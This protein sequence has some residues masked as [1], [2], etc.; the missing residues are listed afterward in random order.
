MAGADWEEKK[1]MNESQEL[2]AALSSFG[3]FTHDRPQQ[4]ARLENAIIEFYYACEAIVKLESLE[5]KE[6]PAP[7]PVDKI[8]E[9]MES[10][11][12]EMFG[13]NILAKED[14]N[15]R[16]KRALVDELVFKSPF[17]LEVE[18]NSDNREL[19]K[20][21]ILK[22][23]QAILDTVYNEE[24]QR[25]IKREILL[26]ELKKWDSYLAQKQEQELKK[27]P[28]NQ[29]AELREQIKNRRDA[30][31]RLNPIIQYA[32]EQG[33]LLPKRRVNDG[34]NLATQLEE[35]QAAFTRERT[36]LE[37]GIDTQEQGCLKAILAVIACCS[38]K[39]STF[40]NSFWNLESNS[41]RAQRV[42]KLLKSENENEEKK[43]STQAPGKRPAAKGD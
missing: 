42:G 33:N 36:T 3:Y 31:A 10:K 19:Q 5:S 12:L 6:A 11:L 24:S 22:Q 26:K 7:V 14:I 16:I 15:K 21:S 9:M 13:P 29:N 4:R 2:F 34:E 43:V 37:E 30:L 17:E 28:K 32:D 8:Y 39:V 18:P 35:F 20:R 1:K 23:F 40:I 38:T 27:Q 25:Q 41:Q